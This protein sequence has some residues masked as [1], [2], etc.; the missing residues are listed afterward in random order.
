MKIILRVC[1]LAILHCMLGSIVSAQTLNVTYVC[2]AEHIYLEYC[3]TQDLS[4]KARCMIAHPDKPPQNGGMVYTYDT[5]GNLKNLLA[6][7]QQPSADEIARENAFRK[8]VKDTQDAA[9]KKNLDR[10]ASIQSFAPPK[11]TQLQREQAEIRECIEAGREPTTCMGETMQKSLQGMMSEVAPGIAKTMLN[12]HPPGLYLTGVYKGA[13]NFT[14]NFGQDGVSVVCR[15]MVPDWHSYT[16]EMNGNRAVVNIQ[17]QPHPFNLAFQPDGTVVGSA[18]ID[19]KGSVVVGQRTEW[20]INSSTNIPYAESTPVL[21]ATTER[22][23]I[24]GLKGSTSGPQTTVTM[25]MDLLDPGSTKLI[26]PGLRVEG[27][28]M[29]NGGFGIK[30]HTDAAVVRCGA[31][32]VAH[33]YTM[34]Q[35]ADQLLLELKDVGRPIVFAY[36][37]DGTLAGSG[38]IQVNGRK[39]VGQKENGDMI[40]APQSAAC[41]MGI[42]SARR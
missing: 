20:K 5:R 35:R 7:C 31:A 9:Q 30:F 1:F 27:E 3:S 17:A 37:P 2:S 26:P 12:Q 14:A 24:G 40:F 8:K 36:R 21:R 13:A 39:I 22:C 18:A 19:L 41:T 29:G 28:Y 33:D 25:T 11:P 23:E 10:M 32:T 15:D 42:L 6:T 16:V 38:P 4:D 34:V